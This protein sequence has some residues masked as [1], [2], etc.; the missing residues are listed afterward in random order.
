M[1]YRIW[2]EMIIGGVYG[3]RDKP[4]VTS[5]FQRAGGNHPSGRKKDDVSQAL[6]QI[7]S[8]ITPQRNSGNSSNGSSPATKTID[9]RSKCYRQLADLKNLRD[10][11]TEEEFRVERE[12]ILGILKS[13]A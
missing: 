9:G 7:V 6:G 2:S 5:M 1:Q 10:I 3:N 8:A 12:A 13:L 11:L 4:P